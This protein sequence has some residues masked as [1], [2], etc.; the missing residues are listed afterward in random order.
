MTIGIHDLG[1]AEAVDRLVQR[2][3]AEAGFEGVRDA[4]SQHLAGEP[5]HDGDQVEEPPRIG[6]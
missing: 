6:K 3:N 1:R 2:L 5:V 4:P